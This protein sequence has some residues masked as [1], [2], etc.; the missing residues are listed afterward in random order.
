MLSEDKYFKTLTKD[1]LWKRYC[2]FLDL[3]IDQFMDIQKELLMDEIE[4]VSDSVLGRKIMGDHKPE[5]LEEFRCA[6][7]LT[8]Y[9]DYEPY[10]SERQEDALATK[11]FLWCHSSGRG[12][13][14]KWIPQSHTYME[15]VTRYFIAM[16]ILSSASRRGEINIG[17]GLRLLTI[18]PPAPYASGHMFRF[19]PNQ[20]SMQMIPPTER[21]EK[22]E[23]E[24]RISTG[25]QMALR[26]GVDVMGSIASVLVKMGETFSEQTR[27]MH[28]SASM[29]HPKVLVRL[30]RAL[31]YSKKER[32]VILPKDLW[33]TKAIIAS[34]ADT[35]I[36]KEE[37]ARYWGTEPY[38]V[39]GSAEAFTLAMQ[40]WERKGL[41]FVPD[42][43][44]LEFIPYEEEIAHEDDKDYQ[45]STLL[46]NEVEEGKSYEIVITQFDSMPLMRYRTKD[47]VKV[48]SLRDE[49]AQIYLPQINFQRRVHDLIDLA[50][51]ARLDEKTI[52]RAIANTGIKYTDWSACKEYDHNKAYL[53]IYLELKEPKEITE[54]ETMIDE[55][56]KA[57]DTD[58]KDIDAYL[59]LRLVRV[60]ILPPGTFQRYINQKRKEGA[61]LAHL[62]PSH[63]NPPDE[64]IERLLELSK[65]S[66]NV[67]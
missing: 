7:P 58:Y 32:R 28:F 65:A 36:Y 27:G 66:E 6:V 26:D 33:P 67:S 39:Y 29:L 54:L 15:R 8:T 13:Y 53:R 4:R 41:Y 9:D 50:G 48:I 19:I 46:F 63:I 55:Q 11:P 64:A 42:N 20:F 23:F 14:F 35:A 2:G 62:K 22:M 24:E 21:S 30:I 31:L 45:L 59:R 17:P 10:L 16:S 44:F 12:G 25:F 3:S 51:L 60:T 1:E 5:S 52:W 61:D 56:L 47:I 49:K 38:E 37:I 57:V 43:V 18:L 34:G 40:T